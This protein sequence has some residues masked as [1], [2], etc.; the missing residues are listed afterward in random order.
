[1]SAPPSDTNTRPGMRWHTGVGAR[2]CL[3]RRATGA[4]KSAAATAT[5]TIPHGSVDIR[6]RRTSRPCRAGGSGTA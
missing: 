6:P 1:M 5:A 3:A 2:R 4:A